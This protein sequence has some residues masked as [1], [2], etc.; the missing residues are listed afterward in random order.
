MR[1]TPLPDDRSRR[2]SAARDSDVVMG[3]T[4]MLANREIATRRLAQTN[5][6]YVA[7]CDG[8]GSGTPSRKKG[9]SGEALT[10]GGATAAEAGRPDSALRDRDHHGEDSIMAVSIVATN[11]T[12]ELFA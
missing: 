3:L 10:V 9:D 12:Q 1:S 8:S 5:R 7:G 4:W 2:I 6:P 11:E